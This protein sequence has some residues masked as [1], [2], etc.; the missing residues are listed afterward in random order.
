MP[1]I[2]KGHVQVNLT[3]PEKLVR[4]VKAAAA[5]AG[6]TLSAYIGDRLRD[7]Q[8]VVV[9]GDFEIAPKEPLKSP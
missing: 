3:L 1:Q 5:M 8:G 4:E 2:P 6:K 7:R 9:R